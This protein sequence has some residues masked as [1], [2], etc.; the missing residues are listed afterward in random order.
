M[1]LSTA[2]TYDGIVD[3]YQ[4]TVSR[5][6]P[7]RNAFRDE[8]I[9]AVIDGPVL[10]AGCGPGQDLLDFASM[11]LRAYGVDASP[12]MVQRTR[13]RGAYAVVG[14]VRTLPMRPGTIGA[15]WSSASLLHV[16]R[17]DVP[18]TLSSW[19]TTLRPGGLLGLITSIG[20]ED[21]WESVPYKPGTQH[22]GAQLRRWFVHHQP[23][24][25]IGLIKDCGFHIAASST[26]SGTR[27]WLH[28][29]A[30]A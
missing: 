18:T 14:D 26:R 21:G 3:S 16:P 15:I 11:G 1:L 28:V 27:D 25:L 22:T 6:A 8:F 9:R 30:T 7:E 19:H 29:L 24:A 10:D 17:D 4:V 23:E 13:E 12:A 20:D 5:P 2:R